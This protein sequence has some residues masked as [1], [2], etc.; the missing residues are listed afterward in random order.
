MTKMPQ[1]ATITA[2]TALLSGCGGPSD[3]SPA[4]G[5]SAANI[6]ASACQSCHGENGAGKF[7]FLF[8]IAGSESSPEEMATALKEGGSIMPSFPNLSDKQR[9]MMAAYVK[10]F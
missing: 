1:I 4:E 10:A 3:F 8:K 9:T 2:L 7:G 5:M 6:Y